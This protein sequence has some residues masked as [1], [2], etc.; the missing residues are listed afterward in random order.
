MPDPFYRVVFGSWYG[1]TRHVEAEGLDAAAA[2][3][4][5]LGT[6][7]VY[8]G[9]RPGS[10]VIVEEQGVEP[11]RIARTVTLATDLRG[12][13]HLVER[14]DERAPWVPVCAP[15]S[16]S[17]EPTAIHHPVSC[18]DCLLLTVS[19]RPRTAPSQVWVDRRAKV[20]RELVVLTLEKGALGLV[21]RCA[22]FKGGVFTGREHRILADT[23]RDGSRYVFLE[24]S[25]YPTVHRHMAPFRYGILLSASPVRW[26]AEAFDPLACRE[27]PL[28]TSTPAP[29]E[30]DR[31]DLWVAAIDP[32]QGLRRLRED[33]GH[34]VKRGHEGGTSDH[35]LPTVERHRQVVVHQHHLPLRG[36]PPRRRARLPLPVPERHQVAHHTHLSRL[37]VERA[38]FFA[39]TRTSWFHGL[40][41]PLWRTIPQ[42]MPSVGPSIP[43]RLAYAS[44]L[45]RIGW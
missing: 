13:V 42:A 10:R 37:K 3:T 20:L 1:K 28:W 38:P 39:M 4:V 30:D 26:L 33:H 40:S 44:M 12:L 21:A 16:G 11:P 5:A 14:G 2:R 34:L 43:A 22:V 32:G 27:G 24:L 23:L 6:A 29:G 18:P 19:Y 35:L 25:P 36:R 7:A 17:P 9:R 41:W 31:R 15:A 8:L 45:A